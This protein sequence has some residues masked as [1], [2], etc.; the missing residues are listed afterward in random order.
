[1]L[2]DRFAQHDKIVVDKYVDLIANYQMTTYD[3]VVRASVN[4]TTNSITITLPSVAEA[5]GRFYSILARSVADSKTITIAHKGDSEGWTNIVLS[6]TGDHCFLYSD[7]SFWH[8]QTNVVVVDTTAAGA[9]T[10]GTISS[11]SANAL[12]EC[13]GFIVINGKYV[14]Y[15]NNITP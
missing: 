12:G 13:N 1:M 7:G 5:K 2:E 9:G 14:P 6:V 8:I 15:W 4:S 3:Y 10:D 11:R